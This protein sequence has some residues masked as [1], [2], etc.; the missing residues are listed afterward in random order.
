MV[1]L[2]KVIKGCWT[3]VDFGIRGIDYRGYLVM[4]NLKPGSK[5]GDRL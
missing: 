5:I 4:L 2:Y 1:G 3:L